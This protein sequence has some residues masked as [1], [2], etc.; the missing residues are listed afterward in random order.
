MFIQIKNIWYHNVYI[1]TLF[2]LKYNSD[3]SCR[4]GEYVHKAN[5]WYK[6]AVHILYIKINII[7]LLS[8]MSYINLN[9]L[10]RSI[11]YI[12]IMYTLYIVLYTMQYTCHIKC[13]K[14]I[15]T[16]LLKEIGLSLK[17]F[18]ILNSLWKLVNFETR[19]LIK[20]AECWYIW[21]S[22]K[23]MNSYLS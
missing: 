5:F 16:I 13:T 19:N 10:L 15:Q 7:F 2:R 23:E 4:K 9:C 21:L 18:N 20:V 22:A 3:T 14:L 12:S 11:Q 6:I 1:H 8:N 17:W